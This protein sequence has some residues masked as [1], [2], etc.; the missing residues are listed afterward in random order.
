MGVRAPFVN[1]LSPGRGPA[2]GP[3]RCTGSFYG[4]VYGPGRSYSRPATKLPA[5]ARRE[6]LVQ[7]PVYSRRLAPQV[8]D[9]KLHGTIKQ[10]KPDA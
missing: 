9:D 8:K 1:F 10:A 7:G 6:R 4:P 5:D 3:I 2:Y